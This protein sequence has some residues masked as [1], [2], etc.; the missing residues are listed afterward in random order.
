NPGAF[1]I[2]TFTSPTFRSGVTGPTG[3]D[4]VD[5]GPD[6]HGAVFDFDFKSLA[7]GAKKK[8]RIFYGAA[9]NEVDALAAI[10]VI[11]VELYSLGQP[12]VVG[13]PN[14]GTPNTFIFAFTQVGG[15]PVVTATDTTTTVTSNL[16]TTT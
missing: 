14:L 16:S 1:T 8:F 11:G 2:R 15:D 12:N 13:G 3:P 7:A 10:G 4:L 6:D 9:G 5:G